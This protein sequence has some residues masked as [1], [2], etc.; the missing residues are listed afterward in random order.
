M[1]MQEVRKK[2][3]VCDGS[4]VHEGVALSCHETRLGHARALLH[5]MESRLTTTFDAA[6]IATPDACV[7]ARVDACVEARVETAQP[8][9]AFQGECN[10]VGANMPA[11]IHPRRAGASMHRLLRCLELGGV[12]EICSLGLHASWPGTSHETADARQDGQVMLCGQHGAQPGHSAFEA[13]AAVLGAVTTDTASAPH[14]VAPYAVLMFLAQWIASK[15]DGSDQSG[16]PC[17]VAWIGDRVHPDAGAFRAIP[18]LKHAVR[19]G[20]RGTHGRDDPD[21]GSGEL[22]RQGEDGKRDLASRSFF[23]RDSDRAFTPVRHGHLARSARARRT[24]AARLEMDVRACNRLWCAEQAI[25]M[26]AAG[27]LIID[28]NGFSPLAWRRLQLAVDAGGG[29]ACDAA[30]GSADKVM[31]AAAK[32]M[33]LDREGL[34]R[35]PCVLVVVPSGRRGQA[36]GCAATARWSVHAAVPDCVHHVDSSMEHSAAAKP[37][38]A[39]GFAWRLEMVSARRFGLQALAHGGEDSHGGGGVEVV[40]SRSTEGAHAEQSWS[41]VAERAAQRRRARA[42]HHALQAPQAAGAR[43][44]DD[45]DNTVGRGIIATFAARAE[46]AVETEDVLGGVRAWRARSA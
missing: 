5:E 32:P 9:R 14:A 38:G 37:C 24:N 35:K 34:H 3:S 46:S 31:A 7:D 33:S 13:H 21:G 19:H 17:H 10:V 2:R 44:A 1:I 4:G 45:P 22:G 40:M 15:H 42:I 25:R 41:R 23:V 43:G 12:H 8:I 11:S 30:D 16:G 6:Q 29:A 36:A 39:V 27:V 26:G 20:W 28:G 18:R